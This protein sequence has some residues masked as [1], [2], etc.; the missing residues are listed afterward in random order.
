MNIKP[1]Q[2]WGQNM[3]AGLEIYLKSESYLYHLFSTGI[4]KV[5]LSQF[6]LEKHFK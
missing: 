4:Q 3:Q 5:T 1:D 2:V 6:Y